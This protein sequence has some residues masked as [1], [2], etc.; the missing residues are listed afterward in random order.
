MALPYIP[1]C[2]VVANGAWDVMNEPTVSVSA[3]LG[4]SA[5]A[6]WKQLGTFF[7][8]PRSHRSRYEDRGGNM[9]AGEIQKEIGQRGER[10]ER[11][12]LSSSAS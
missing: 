11:I 4:I 9:K 8:S 3:R 12:L 1:L 10:R 2:R 6:D 7:S 5:K